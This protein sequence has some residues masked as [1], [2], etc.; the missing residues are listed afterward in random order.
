[1]KKF[2][3]NI[4]ETLR[5][6]MEKNTLHYQ[7]DFDLDMDTFKR[8]AAS[9]DQEDKHLVWLSRPNGTWCLNEREVYLIGTSNYSILQYYTDS[10][11]GKSIQAF[12]IDIIEIK[13]DV[14]YGNIHQIDYLQYAAAVKKNAI[15]A[16]HIEMK[17]EKGTAIERCSAHLPKMHRIFGAV[18]QY[19]YLPNDENE[20]NDILTEQRKR[21][22]YH[23]KKQRSKKKVGSV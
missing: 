13:N 8:M 22:V 10:E 3:V 6:I 15:Q 20:L 7:S 2:N 23:E 11:E 21:R 9:K 5:P 16:T 19:K 17:C 12:L 18:Q 1:M 4:I 14:V